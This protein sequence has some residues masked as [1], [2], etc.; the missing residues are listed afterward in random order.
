MASVSLTYPGRSKIGMLQAPLLTHLSPL[1]SITFGTA[2]SAE[3][4]CNKGLGAPISIGRSAETFLQN[5]ESLL[6]HETAWFRPG[7]LVRR[8]GGF[9]LPAEGLVP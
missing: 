8:K 7:S 1:Q 2:A 9:E 6:A 4:R 5:F 3:F